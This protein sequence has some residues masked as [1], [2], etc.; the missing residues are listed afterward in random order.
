MRILS[1]A[2][3]LLSLLAGN[4]SFAQLSFGGHPHGLD[5]ASGLPQPPVVTMPAV[6]VATLMAEDEARMADGE[7]GPYRFGS[8][9]VVDIGLDNAGVWRTLPNGDH[10]WRTA[11]H[12]PGALSINLEFH[13]FEIPDGAM[14]FLYNDLGDVLGGF[15][16]G[17]N[18]GHTELGVDL[19]AGERITVEY[20]EPE[21]VA[22]RGRLRIGQVTHGYRDV[23]GITRGFNQSGACNN[24]VICPVGDP[25]RDQIRSVAIMVTGGNGFCTGQFLNNCNNDGT[26]YFLTANHCMEDAGSNIIF[27]FNWQS[28]S[29]TP[30]TNGPTNQT[31]AG[32]TLLRRDAGSDVALLRLNTTPPA[33]YNVF[34]SGWNAGSSAATGGI[35]GIHHPSGDIKKI[36]T[37][38]QSVTSEAWR[39][40]QCWRVNSWSNGTTEPGSSGSGIWN[41]NGL[42]VGQLYGG[43]SACGN[44]GQDYYGKFSVSYPLLREWLGNCGPV[45]QGYPLNTAGI[46]DLPVSGTLNIW[47]NPGSGS[48]TMELPSADADGHLIRV[49][50]AVGRTVNE[51]RTPAGAARQVR[52]D[53]EGLPA[54]L[55]MVEAR[56][57]KARLQQRLVISH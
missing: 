34:Y 43:A 23:F 4:G 37:T 29:C 57:A 38:T 32:Y 46:D 40:A 16:A 42:L 53:L 15:D 30:N 26:P 13:Q 51:E 20:V 52:L 25:W 17:S 28:P 48:F 8:N 39:G 27:R 44:N 54:G 31:L 9:H 36:S 3:V 5:R 7:K 12:C 18:P 2:F 33:A 6:D 50:D 41:R 21:R 14:V 47:P 24:N 11:I 10:V 19:L 55:Y 49:F 35:T 22:G 45:L 1:S 56:S